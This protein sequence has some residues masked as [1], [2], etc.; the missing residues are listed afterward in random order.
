MGWVLFAVITV[1]SH[2]FH[3]TFWTLEDNFT[4]EINRSHDYSGLFAYNDKLKTVEGCLEVIDDVFK[5]VDINGDGVLDR[6]EDAS[7]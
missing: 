4:C 6:C 3:L 2:I 7:L 1:G 5:I